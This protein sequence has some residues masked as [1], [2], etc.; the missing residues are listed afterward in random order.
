[1]VGMPGI[2]VFPRAAETDGHFGFK[3]RR[4]EIIVREDSNVS[5]Q[6]VE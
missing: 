3:G 2:R 1:M 6:Q 4:K 5:P